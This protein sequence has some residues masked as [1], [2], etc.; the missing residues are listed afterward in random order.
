MIILAAMLI[1]PL[2]LLLSIKIKSRL[3]RLLPSLICAAL[4]I[5]M[6]FK[7]ATAT[8]WDA[9]FYVCFAVYALFLLLICGIAQLICY[10]LKP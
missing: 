6:L 2:Q 5:F 10:L 8:E 9:L 4:A 7:A 1:F 3:L